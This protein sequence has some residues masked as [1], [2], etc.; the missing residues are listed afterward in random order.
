ML[1]TFCES[2]QD[3]KSSEQILL[4]LNP[5][6]RLFYFLEILRFL[7]T[8]FSAVNGGHMDILLNWPL[9]YLVTKNRKELH[10]FR[11][12]Y[13]IAVVLQNLN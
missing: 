1:P 8:K 3:A 10:I 4:S 7:G 5:E 9:K 12:N 13:T 11:K 6:K 2:Y